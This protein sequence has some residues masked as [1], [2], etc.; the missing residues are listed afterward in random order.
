METFI[1]HLKQQLKLH[2]VNM[3]ICSDILVVQH[4]LG[5]RYKKLLMKIKV[6]KPKFW[7]CNK[8][9]EKDNFILY[10]MD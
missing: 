3:A 8:L 9:Q 10:C 4:I 7:H 1:R 6:P 2:I 5:Y